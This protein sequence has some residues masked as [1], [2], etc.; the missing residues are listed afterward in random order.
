MLP[1]LLDAMLET[2]VFIERR[3]RIAAR[4][5]LDSEVLLVG[6]GHPVPLPENT[7]QTYPFLAHVEYHYLA[8]LECPG[9]VIAYDPQ[10]PP[11]HRWV[12]FV[13]TVTEDERVWEGRTQPPGNPLETLDAWLTRRR[14]RPLAAL[15]EPPRGFAPDL[16]T[17]ARVRDLLKHAR[18]EKDAHELAL[19]RRA[20]AA[21]A[22]GY[23]AV[24]P[25]VRPGVSERT[26][27]IELEAAF[28]RAGAS[29]TGYST[30]VGAG[31]NAAVLHFAP[32]AR[33]LQ[34][35][36]FLLVDAGA[37]VDRY[38]CDVTRTHI[39]GTSSPFRRDLHAVVLAAE[40][41]AI[42]RCLPGAEWRDIH[43]AA[44]VDLVEGLVAMG[45]MRGRPED[46]V[47]R[48][49]HTLFF[50][51][52]LGHMVGLGV[53]D[54]SGTAPGRAR[55]TDPALRNLRTDMPL[56]PG[57]VM[58][59]EPGLYFIPPLLQ[60]PARRDRFHD[61][62]DWDLVDRHLHVG[63]VRIEDNIVVREDGPPENLTAAI[64]KQAS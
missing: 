29:G 38:V 23:E 16:A 59:V 50:P 18:R 22:A 35:G 5:G 55:S 48:A 46:L 19:L 51:H 6:A 21:T 3:A 37:A 49:A 53:R 45:V 9:A 13:P 41:R 58:T 63:G 24:A 10:E 33:V 44:A 1:R 47:A 25:L 32:T 7:D 12:S 28:L 56:A 42:A 60:D 62:V 30:I 2:P 40:E 52:G 61:A 39:V 11:A 17:T 43:L 15:G 26:L 64:P 4:L 27:Q 34:D 36:D 57:Y 8:G 14:G 54:A 31:S 20:A